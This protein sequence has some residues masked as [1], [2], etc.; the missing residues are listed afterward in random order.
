MLRQIF[1]IVFLTF[2]LT[3][4]YSLINQ[5]ELDRLS[6]AVERRF[7]EAHSKF[8]E[9]GNITKELKDFYRDF[10][11]ADDLKGRDLL[12]RDS[13]LYGVSRCAAFE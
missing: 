12:S 6:V 8:V 1:L 13:G 9:T 11:L 7:F 4:A 3:R 5:D 10:R 2:A